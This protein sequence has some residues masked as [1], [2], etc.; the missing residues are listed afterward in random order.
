MAKSKE[1]K[2]QEAL[3]RQRKSYAMQL[4][5]FLLFSPTH[6]LWDYDFD[7][8]LLWVRR[9]NHMRK[10]AKEY[11]I[12]Y[13]G[14]DTHST[15]VTWSTKQLLDVLV[16]TGSLM[17]T[18]EVMQNQFSEEHRESL[19]LCSMDQWLER[20]PKVIEFLNHPKTQELFQS[21]N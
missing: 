7:D 20:K 14:T 15:S 17:H 5:Y 19:T 16:V 11:G 1:Q 18:C 4:E 3:E 2:Q 8:F 10:L 9:F 13:D 12:H 6:K 21:F